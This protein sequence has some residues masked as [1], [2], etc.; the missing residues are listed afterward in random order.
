MKQA[1]ETLS[2]C[3]DS[4]NSCREDIYQLLHN[5]A[6]TDWKKIEFT[7][8]ADLFKSFCLS[9]DIL[10]A[11][12]KYENEADRISHLLQK[13]ENEIGS[14]KAE[15]SLRSTDEDKAKLMARQA[16]ENCKSLQQPMSV[17]LSYRD[18]LIDGVKTLREMLSLEQLIPL[19]HNRAKKINDFEI[20]MKVFRTISEE[21]QN[22]AGP[23]NVSDLFERATKVQSQ[24]EKLEF[25]DT[26]LPDL[27]REIV[28]YNTNICLSAVDQIRDFLD[29]ISHDSEDELQPIKKIKKN[30][31]AIHKE[32]LPRLLSGIDNQ[33]DSL[34]KLISSYHMSAHLLDIV[35]IIASLLDDIFFYYLTIKND[36]FAKLPF[37]ASAPN[38]QLHPHTTARLLSQEYF[39]GFKGLSRMIRLMIISVLGRT[40]IIN[41]KELE[42]MMIDFLKTCGI[43][44]GTEKSDIAKL[45]KIIQSFL[46]PYSRPFPY[47]ELHSL[48]KRAL[49]DFGSL[50]EDYLFSFEVDTQKADELVATDT[51]QDTGKKIRLGKLIQEIEVRIENIEL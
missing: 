33:I 50:V 23:E 12:D 29:T 6:V 1:R 3:H 47:N 46:A 42:A 37:E 14:F 2:R 4:L 9:P 51:L 5:P 31:K 26:D 10:Q 38:S 27:V 48:L 21:K 7:Q 30:L 17:L 35:P 15:L 11:R 25:P 36:L 24:L 43:F 39:N 40:K 19:A 18:I 41:E 22:T 34:A 16:E 32:P 28:A 49:S 45:D 20:G 13:L 44:Y 8:Y